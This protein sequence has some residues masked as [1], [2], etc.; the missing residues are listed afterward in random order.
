MHMIGLRNLLLGG[1][2]VLA[3]GTHSAIQIKT[4]IERHAEREQLREESV[5]LRASNEQIQGRNRDLEETVAL[6]SE[7]DAINIDVLEEIARRHFKM[8]AAGEILLIIPKDAK[9]TS[10]V[11]TTPIVL[12]KTIEATQE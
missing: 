2:C 6:I 12:E 3:L 8:S 4:L 1:G 5:L 9:Q 11:R 10:E 7:P